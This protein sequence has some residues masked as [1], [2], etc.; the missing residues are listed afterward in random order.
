MSETKEKTAQIPAVGAAGEQSFP[1]N[2]TDN[3][4]AENASE[5]NDEFPRRN[6]GGLSASW[7]LTISTRYP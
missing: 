3:S 6:R 5:F 7:I 1:N 2:V 4:I